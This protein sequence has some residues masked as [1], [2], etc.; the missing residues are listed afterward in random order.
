M[1]EYF[2]SMPDGSP[3][4]LY[5]FSVGKLTVSITDLG[6]TLVRILVPD[7]AGKAEDMILGYDRGEDYLKDSAN[8]FGAT[9]GRSANRIGGASFELGG[10]EYSLAKNDN[11][12]NL[13]SGPDHWFHR[14]WQVEEVTDRSIR[15]SLFSP[16]GDQGF[17]GNARVQVT[18]RLEEPGSIRISY[19]A[20][21]DR[22]TLFNLTNHC[23][24]NL[25]G[26][27]HPEK[28]MLQTLCMPARFFLPDDPFNIPTGEIRPVDGTPMDFRAPKPLNRDLDADYEPLKLQHGY[29]HNFDVWC[30]PCAVL[31]DPE[32][33]RTLRISTD[34]P[35]IQLYTGNFVDAVGKNGCRYFHRS[36]VALETQFYPDAIHHPHWPQPVTR[37]GEHYHSDTL[38]EF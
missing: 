20:V 14:L 21:S 26:C 33:G 1:K 3:I 13:H 34:C 36:G 4:S 28:A 32:S 10:I 22:D 24:F 18:Y 5:T 25:A 2:G 16:D 35:G 27:D 38:L 29:D 30:N 7:A 37:A 6:A 11:E 15:F 23:Y 19:D 12:N 17:P 31:Q 8:C 9:V